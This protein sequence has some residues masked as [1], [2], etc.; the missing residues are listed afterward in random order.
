MLKSS[1][2][3]CDIFENSQTKS[4]ELTNLIK[5]EHIKPCIEEIV[6]QINNNPLCEN[7]YTFTLF[8]KDNFDIYNFD[9]K[10]LTFCDRNIFIGNYYNILKN[11]LIFLHKLEKIN[12]DRFTVSL[13]NLEN[14]C[15]GM[16]HFISYYRNIETLPINNSLIFK[17]HIKNNF[18]FLLDLDDHR[19][20]NKNGKYVSFEEFNRIYKKK[21]LEDNDN[22]NFV[23]RDSDLLDEIDG[24]NLTFRNTITTLPSNVTTKNNFQIETSGYSLLFG[25]TFSTIGLFFIIFIVYLFFVKIIKKK[26]KR[27]ENSH[28]YEST[29][30]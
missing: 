25:A 13:K 21:Y 1:Q 29:L 3:T 12:I 20:K 4:K 28:Q 27:T 5:C 10:I 24:K 8:S 19:E 7:F 17:K 15:L 11:Y 6:G 26:Q 9:S 23:L 2:L 30:L 22:F 14:M 18:D 16:D